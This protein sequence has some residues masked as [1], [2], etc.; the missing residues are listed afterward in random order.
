M[1]KT[2][3][4][5]VSPPSVPWIA[6]SSLV[7]QVK[8]DV[9]EE[10][11]AEAASEEV[12]EPLEQ[13]AQQVEDQLAEDHTTHDTNDDEVESAMNEADEEE[14]V[15][16]FTDLDAVTPNKSR[17]D[18]APASLGITSGRKVAS[19]SESLTRTTK[20]RVNDQQQLENR[21][22]LKEQP[23]VKP[24]AGAGYQPSERLLKTTQARIADTKEWAASRER[25]NY[26]DDIWWELRRPPPHSAKLDNIH[27]KL[28][29]PTQA[30]KQSVRRKKTESDR[31]RAASPVKEVHTSAIDPNSP[32][33]KTTRGMLNQAWGATRDPEAA[34]VLVLATAHSG[35]Q[36]S[37][38]VMEETVATLHAKWRP[39]EEEEPQT[40]PSKDK[41]LVKAP[42]NRLLAFNASMRNGRRDKVTKEQGDARERGWNLNNLAKDGIPPVEA[43]FHPETVRRI[44]MSSRSRSPGRGSFSS[45]RS[46]VE[47]PVE[48]VGALAVEAAAAEAEANG[49]DEEPAAHSEPIHAA[50]LSDPNPES[51][52]PSY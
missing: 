43:V 50:E 33:L 8:A 46:S 48:E 31:E 12:Q 32:L 47:Y 45:S 34:P 19:P 20:A 14:D 27:S 26:D 44:S 25:V 30:F 9:V 11:Q 3:A 28:L 15:H 2:K 40:S 38:K 23:K 17:R 37:S 6:S 16:D 36:V 22:R 49:H 42:S 35:P 4:K 7:V 5:K 41:H 52:V 39:K 29:E 18:S 10:P 51:G 13:V 21:R 24:S 1:G